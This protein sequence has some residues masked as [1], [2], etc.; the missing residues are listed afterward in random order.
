MFV[1][2]LL[3]KIKPVIV[4]ITHRCPNQNKCPQIIKTNFDKLDTDTKASYILGDFDIN[5]YKR[6]K[7]LV[8]EYNRTSLKFLSSNIKNDHQ[9]YTM[10]GLNQLIKSP[11]CVTCSTSTSNLIDHMIKSNLTSFPTRVSQKGVIDVRISDH[12]LLSCTHKISSLKTSSTYKYLNLCSFKNYSANFYKEAL[13]QLK[14]RNCQTFDDI[15]DGL[16]QF[17]KEND[18]RY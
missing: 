12:Q 17:F 16:F 15:N 9:F 3:P 13:K 10:H 5:N 14:F 2:V 11:T 7:Y 4:G 8:C 18:D 1:K 6:N